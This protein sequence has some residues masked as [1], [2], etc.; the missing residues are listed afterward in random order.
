MADVKRKIVTIGGGTG[1]FVVLSGLKRLM[2]VTLTAIVSV[3]DDGG[4]TGRLRDAYGYLPPGDARQALVALADD[5]ELIRKL[6]SYRFTKGDV[7]GHNLGNL[8]LTGLSDILGSGAD[9]IDA[10][11]KTLRV[12]GVV[13]PVSIS[14]ATLVA[15]LE[16]GT[17]LVGEHVIDERQPNRSHVAKLTTREHSEANPKAVEAIRNANAIIIGPGDLYTSTL[18]DFAVSGISEAVRASQAK[19][20]YI[21]NLFTKAGQTDGYSALKHVSEIEK[22]LGRKPDVILIHSGVF[23]K[24]VLERYAKEH[25]YPV[26]DDLLDSPSVIRGQFA[27]VLVAEKIEGDTVPRSLIRHSSEKIASAIEKIL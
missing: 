6:F 22:H 3:L 12:K 4:S 16:D 14:P 20:I 19:L 8:L 24:D 25:E 17:V 7:A 2:N 23:A 1:T 26:E 10:A 15:E 21:V 13:L 18:A 11:S 27:D 9:A 5:D